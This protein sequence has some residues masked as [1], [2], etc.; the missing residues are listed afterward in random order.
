MAARP[1]WAEVSLG[2][3]RRNFRRIRQHVGNDVKVCAVVKAQA[4][5]H[6]A[7][8]CARALEQEGV[9]WL[10]VTSTAEGISLRQAGIRG[11]VLLMTGFWRGDEAEAI[12]GDLTP[13]VWQPW[14]LAALER[15][16][17]AQSCRTPIHVKLDSGMARL[18]V[19]LGE[20]EKFAQELKRCPHLRVEGVM[21]HLASAEVV[22][23]AGNDQQLAR[24]NEALAR[25]KGLGIVPEIVHAANSAAIISRPQSW[26]DMV[27]PGLALYG[28]YLPFLSSSGR[29]TETQGLPVEPVLSWK[30]RI[31]GL[32]DVPAGQA[33]GY[34][35][36]YITPAAARIAVLPVGYADGLNR[37]LSSVGR[38]LVRGQIA[39]IVGIVSMDITTIDLTG[40]AGVEIGDEVILLGESRAP[41]GQGHRITAWEHATLSHTLPYEILCAIS[42]RVPRR[43]VE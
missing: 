5:G 12:A 24:F 20:L 28:Y 36:S 26:R 43:Y 30:T 6:G 3:L 35:G 23:A 29:P 7:V 39:P 10:G 4:Y 18:G 34:G 2:A 38:V 13:A 32:R 33:I 41:N 37:H 21:T 8:E 22:D 16:A 40:I 14:E 27:R 1:T 11:R 31:V 25:L 17:A 15:A 42:A 19:P 9:P